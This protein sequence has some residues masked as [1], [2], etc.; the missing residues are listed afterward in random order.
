MGEP[1]RVALAGVLLALAGALLWGQVVRVS[2]QTALE[3]TRKRVLLLTIDTLRA[4]HV[5]T[6][7]H[8]PAN[9]P[10]LD[11]SLDGRI[12]MVIVGDEVLLSRS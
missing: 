4:D 2:P 11:R 8:G 7:P 9:T 5:A 12:E 6:R 10:F 1:R 3:P